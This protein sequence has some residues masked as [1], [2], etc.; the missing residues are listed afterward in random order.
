VTYTLIQFGQTGSGFAGAVPLFTGDREACIDEGDRRGVLD[1]AFH[2]DG[3]EL[4]PRMR[5]GYAIVP[6]G[7]VRAPKKSRRAFAFA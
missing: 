6:A 1:R 5:R 4:A 2:E 7:L 3:T